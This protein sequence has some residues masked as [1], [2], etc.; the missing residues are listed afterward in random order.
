[1]LDGV[2]H[3]RPDGFGT[4]RIGHRPHDRPAVQPIADG[5][6]GEARLHRRDE[7][8]VDGVLH[9]EAGRRDADLAGVAQLRCGQLGDGAIEVGV[10]EHDNRRMPAQF[11]GGGLHG[12]GRQAHQVL[13][14]H[15][16]A[17]EAELADDRTGEQVTRYLVGNAEHQLGHALGQ[18]SIEQS[19]KNGHGRC[20]GF[21]G[22]LQDDRAPRRDGRAKLASRIAQGEIP[23]REGGH[24]PDGNLGHERALSGG[25]HEDAAVNPLGFPG[26][27][28]KQT[29]DDMHLDARLGD[30]LAFF[31]R[32]VDGD[33]FSPLVQQPRGAAQHRGAFGPGGI[34]PPPKS[35][36]GG[37]QGA[38]K[39]GGLDEG[40][41]PQGVAGGRIAHREG[42]P[43][44][45]GDPFAVDMQ[46][47]SRIGHSG[48]RDIRHFSIASSGSAT[49]ALR[50][51]TSNGAARG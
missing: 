25:P 32:G 2:G 34:A 11:Q 35:S 14:H 3:H 17:R 1:M 15:G 47:D 18:T 8:V 41:L 36:V 4:A 37:G 44:A 24:G 49:E 16:R 27:E 45:S 33:L 42:A 40:N 29:G 26:V 48:A 28:L 50:C 6:G 21:L 9:I 10:I 31:A 19:L 38:I 7:T 13:A 5:G 22:R 30:G 20:G 51:Q 12:L 39:I 43:V 23:R 46:L